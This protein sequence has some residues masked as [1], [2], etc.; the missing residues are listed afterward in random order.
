MASIKRSIAIQST[1]ERILGYVTEPRTL[2]EWIPSMVETRNIIG[3]GEGQQYEWTYKMAGLLLRGQTTV[4]E[5]EPSTRA[6]HQS[7]GTVS[8][9]WTTTLTPRDGWTDVTM[10]VEYTVPIP[11]L[12]KLAEQLAIRR[13][14]RDLEIALTNLKET[15]EL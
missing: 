14:A 13:D 15:L 1:P 9:T 11:V 6:V 2:A 12:G 10:E 5:Y 7:I 4:V 3:G 8:S